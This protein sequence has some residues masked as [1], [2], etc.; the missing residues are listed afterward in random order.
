MIFMIMVLCGMSQSLF[1]VLMIPRSSRERGEANRNEWSEGESG[2]LHWSRASQKEAPEG[3]C[4]RACLHAYVFL[5]AP[6]C[7]DNVELAGM[8]SQT[9]TAP[10]LGN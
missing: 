5:L 2:S 8:G 1:S 3:R 6:F 4:E 7:I 10:R 9:L